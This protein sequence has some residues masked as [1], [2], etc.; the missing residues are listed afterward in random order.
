MPIAVMVSDLSRK[1]NSIFHETRVS[2]R[3]YEKMAF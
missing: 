3:E 1:P 2:D